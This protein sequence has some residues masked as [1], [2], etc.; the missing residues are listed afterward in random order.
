[1]NKTIIGCALSI[2]A[3]IGTALPAYLASKATLKAASKV[4]DFKES[5]S[6]MDEYWADE[7]LPLKTLVKICWK[8]YIPT[9]ISFLGTSGC[10]IGS[11]VLGYK[12]SAALASSYA[13]ANE[14]VQASKQLAKDL[15]KEHPEIPEG[16]C[17]FFDMESLQYFH[18]PMSSILSKVVLSDGLECYVIETPALSEMIPCCY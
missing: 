14:A 3:M 16:E 2:T 10:I 6:D 8:D 4:E 9:A 15:P 5:Q 7:K 17:L 18:A 1:M 11:T 13:L 12:K